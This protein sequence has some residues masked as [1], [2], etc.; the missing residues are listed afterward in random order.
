MSALDEAFAMLTPEHASTV[1]DVHEDGLFSVWRDNA[2]TLNTRTCSPATN[3]CVHPRPRSMSISRSPT[4]LTSN[5]WHRL[6]LGPPMA[7][8]QMSATI[9]T[10]SCSR[11]ATAK[12]RPGSFPVSS[13]YRAT[14][15]I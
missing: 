6:L 11:H 10:S 7:R 15:A 5:Y 14:T 8:E 4:T 2:G 9:Y 13:A 3:T 1:A 12:K